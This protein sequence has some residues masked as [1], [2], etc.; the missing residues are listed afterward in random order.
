[1]SLRLIFV[2]LIA[3]VEAVISWTALIA[4]LV[5]APNRIDSLGSGLFVAF[6]E[7]QAKRQRILSSAG[8]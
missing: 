8:F 1:M 2:K 5:V 4:P 6:M 3:L 7:C